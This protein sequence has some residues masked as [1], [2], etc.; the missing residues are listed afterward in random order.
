MP[1]NNYFARENLKFAAV[2]YFCRKI[3]RFNISSCNLVFPHRI[4]KD[5]YWIMD[6]LCDAGQQTTVKGVIYA[7]DK[8]PPQ[9]RPPSMVVTIFD[10]FPLFT[11]QSHISSTTGLKSWI[12][13]EHHFSSISAI[14]F[15]NTPLYRNI[16]ILAQQANYGEIVR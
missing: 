16:H 4:E 14:F 13:K 12:K 1:K 11:G 10:C 7:W 8:V 9:F 6:V 5:G 3:C 15:Q 2:V